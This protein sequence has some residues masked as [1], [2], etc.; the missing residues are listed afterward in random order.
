[1]LCMFKAPFSLQ[2]APSSMAHSAVLTW[3]FRNS[4]IFMFWQ[5]LTAHLWKWTP[6]G[7]VELFG[8]RNDAQ[9]APWNSSFASQ[10]LHTGVH[11]LTVTSSRLMESHSW[12]PSN[13][14]SSA[15]LYPGWYHLMLIPLQIQG[16]CFISASTVLQKQTLTSWFCSSGLTELSTQMFIIDAPEELI[17]LCPHWCL[18]TGQ[19]TSPASISLAR[20][21][22]IYEQ[23]YCLLS[24]CE[25]FLAP[26]YTAMM[27]I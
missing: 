24:L 27:V 4:A 6:S 9:N 5:N 22:H 10:L 25:P 2:C 23:H 13:F 7:R 1:M 18:R 20:K 21:G 16:R 26:L 17:A 19:D 12:G 11:Y 15:L 14:L 8:I 3:G